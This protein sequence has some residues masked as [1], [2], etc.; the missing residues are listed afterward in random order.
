MNCL[1]QTRPTKFAVSI[2]IKIDETETTLIFQEKAVN[3]LFTERDL[4][5]KNLFS[6][7]KSK[8]KSEENPKPY[9]FLTSEISRRFLP[10]PYPLPSNGIGYKYPNFVEINKNDEVVVSYL[11]DPTTE[12][13]PWPSVT[14]AFVILPDT[15]NP[16]DPQVKIIPPQDY[17]EQPN[18]KDGYRPEILARLEDIDNIKKAVNFKSTNLGSGAIFYPG[19]ANDPKPTDLTIPRLFQNKN[20]YNT[21]FQAMGSKN[22]PCSGCDLCG[23]GDVFLK[24]EDWTGTYGTGYNPFIN[25]SQIY[26]EE[27]NNDPFALLNLVNTNINSN[28]CNRYYKKAFPETYISVLTGDFPSQYTFTFENLKLGKNTSKF[29]DEAHVATIDIKL[30]YDPPSTLAR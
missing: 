3:E 19:A 28:Y 15:G 12:I 4:A 8:S 25:F 6:Y 30:S 1:R 18:N 17:D 24:E 29:I 16:D 5:C 10:P 2:N 20:E 14:P 21:A 27:L 23:F 11:I 26:N 9:I 7:K 13:L 22:R